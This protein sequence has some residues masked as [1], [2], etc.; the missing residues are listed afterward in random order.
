MF[1]K[2]TISVA[3]MGFASGLPLVLIGSTLQAWYTSAGVSIMAVGALTLVGMPYLYKFLWAPLFD[4]FNPLPLDRR[5]TWIVLT[6]LFLGLGLLLM[7]FLNPIKFP[8]LLASLALILAFF[9]ATQDIV[10]D[11]YKVDVLD[12]NERGFGVALSA[13]GYRIAML[14]AGAL[15]LIMAAEWGWR[16]T[17][18][19]M[20]AL[21]FFSV[22]VTLRSPALEKVAP[23]QTFMQAVREPFADFFSSRL[24]THAILIL[25]FVVLYKISEA[26]SL[27]LNS[28]FL[29]KGVGFTLMQVGS[30]SKLALLGGGV[31]GSL[32][33]GFFLSRWSLYFSLIFFGILQMSSNLLFILLLILPKNLWLV[34]GI[35]FTESFCS[36]L[37]SVA[38]VVFLM[39]LCNKKYTATQYA[40]LSAVSALGRVLLGPLAAVMVKHVGWTEFYLWT[41][42]MGLPAIFILMWLNRQKK[43]SYVESM[44]G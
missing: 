26:L 44:P 42:I 34:G 2:R 35:I 39:G 8:W 6:Q 21:M 25:I 24:W 17:Y 36:A 5:R 23:P 11:A 43:F 14:V 7:A 32:I 27:S 1:S 12:Q 15:A 29:L 33:G 22:I 31:L 13:L 18:F 28:Y 38:F 16:I 37:G 41:F 30:V 4:R 20:S 3:L 10:I 9:S 19:V 40:L